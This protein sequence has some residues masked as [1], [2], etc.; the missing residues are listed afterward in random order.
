VEAV[1][2]PI[3]YMFDMF[4]YISP[5][6]S[7]AFGNTPWATSSEGK[8][9]D[10]EDINYFRIGKASES[11]MGNLKS[12]TCKNVALSFESS[13]T[14][15]AED[16]DT[17][18]SG[19][20]SRETDYA[21]SIASLEDEVAARQVTVSDFIV[22]VEFMD[23]TAAAS[24]LGISSTQLANS[25]KIVGNHFVDFLLKTHMKNSSGIDMTEATF[26]TAESAFNPNSSTV[27]GTA[28][29]YILNIC[30]VEFLNPRST[31][32][33]DLEASIKHLDMLSKTPI[34]RSSEYADLCVS[35]TYFDRVFAIPVSITQFTRT[36]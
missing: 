2:A 20:V 3:S 34:I 36:V 25:K 17:S 33:T 31:G 7:R 22:D 23:E 32:G 13:T 1:Y 26:T 16:T 6:T 4:T 27:L 10:V 29:S 30:A 28:Q 8:L 24:E 9:T 11:G 21:S 14:S 18:S 35:P 12:L 5:D 19:P 15:S